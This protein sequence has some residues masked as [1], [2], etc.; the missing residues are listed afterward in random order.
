MATPRPGLN[1][2][3][4][5]IRRQSHR[6][7]S[8]PSFNYY[9]SESSLVG[10]DADE[11]HATHLPALQDHTVRAGFSSLFDAALFDAKTSDDIVAFVKQ[12]GIED[13]FS[14]Y[15][16]HRPKLNGAGIR[17]VCA[18]ASRLLSQEWEKAI[19]HKTLKVPLMKA[20]A[21]KFTE[22]SFEDIFA[23]MSSLAPNVMAL[24]ET[25]AGDCTKAVDRPSRTKLKIRAKVRRIVI[26]AS[27]L[28]N[29]ANQKFNAIQ[30][31]V[32]MFLFGSKAS[33]RVI[34]VMNRLGIAPNYQTIIS[35]LKIK[36]ATMAERL[37]S[38]CKDNQ[39]IWVSY[40]N[41]TYSANV[42]DQ[43]LFNKATY[44]TATAGYVVK[45]HE[46]LARPMFIHD[47][48]QLRNAKDLNELD[49]IPTIDD[50]R[51]ITSA[52]KYFIWEA[53]YKFCK[54]FDVD[55]SKNPF[56]IEEIYKLD[57]KKTPEIIPLRTYDLNEGVVSQMIEIINKIKSDIGLTVQQTIENVVM[58]KGDKGTVD[59][60][61][62]ALDQS[63]EAKLIRQGVRCSVNAYVLRKVA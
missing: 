27:I 24:F 51:I 4:G 44:V 1:L 21:S 29:H 56:S 19:S 38:I 58:F 23:K 17:N 62:Y 54:A 9:T 31:H 8:N 33:K 7:A 25:L 6:L 59:I 32:G 47:D 60:D 3:E 61:R 35:S 40:D 11:I 36:A 12:G 13:L 52:N 10:A 46:S 55:L 41:M 57:P 48:I 30:S 2:T 63:N 43:T 22:F 34:N 15:L 50:Q 42:R 18:L 20:D 37:R 14:A 53:V 5:L 28:A 16:N 39:A 45:P 26:A 49:F